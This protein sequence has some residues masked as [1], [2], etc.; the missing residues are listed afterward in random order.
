MLSK[1]KGSP[2]VTHGFASTPEGKV[3]IGVAVL[4]LLLGAGRPPS[5]EKVKVAV[6]SDGSCAYFVDEES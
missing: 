5:K 1:I 6:R 4:A 2:S 3:A